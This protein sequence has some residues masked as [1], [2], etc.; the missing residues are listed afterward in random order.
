MSQMPAAQSPPTHCVPGVASGPCMASSGGGQARPPDF[1]LH[2]AGASQQRIVGTP[3][4]LSS[5]S[6][7]HPR[8][9]HLQALCQQE[10]AGGQGFLLPSCT[11]SSG[12]FPVG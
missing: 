7:L 11:L 2:W 3:S 4:C 8:E 5:T 9:P 6:H 10:Y 12:G 1:L